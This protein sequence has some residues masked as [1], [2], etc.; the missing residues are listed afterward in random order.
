MIQSPLVLWLRPF[1]V[2]AKTYNPIGKTLCISAWAE[3]F[4][5]AYHTLR[6]RLNRGWDIEKA[7]AG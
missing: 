3:E 2:V 5:I 6:Q 4:G 1:L 7:L